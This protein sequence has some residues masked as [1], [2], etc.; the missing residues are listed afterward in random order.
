MLLI[1]QVCI[2]S[3]IPTVS[4]RTSRN[5]DTI[6]YAINT[7]KTEAFSGL[8]ATFYVLQTFFIALEFL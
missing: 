1:L 3:K 5:A 6:L 8:Q 2:P 7:T 4:S